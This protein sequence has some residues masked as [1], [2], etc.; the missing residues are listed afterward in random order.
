MCIFE[1]QSEARY[2]ICV[3]VSRNETF[4]KKFASMPQR[5]QR[6]IEKSHFIL[7]T[8]LISMSPDAVA[9]SVHCY[10]WLYLPKQRIIY[11]NYVTE[12]CVREGKN[13]PVQPLWRDKSF[14]LV[15]KSP[16]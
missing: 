4:S 15:Y 14:I 13:L 6:E 11:T 1:S 12:G 16:D 5:M 10:S 9:E 7:K 2:N 3:F 8:G